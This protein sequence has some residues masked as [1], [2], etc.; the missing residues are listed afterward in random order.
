MRVFWLYLLMITLTLTAVGQTSV[1]TNCAKF[2]IN[3][4]DSVCLDA[5]VNI[6]PEEVE[7][8]IRNGQKNVLLIFDGWVNWNKRLIN[9]SNLQNETIVDYLKKY[10]IITLYVDDRVV[11]NVKDSLTVGKRNMM[12]QMD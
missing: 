12:Y 4:H 9:M 2:P 6:A 7:R 11:L 3:E 8:I 10:R 1:K 5:Q